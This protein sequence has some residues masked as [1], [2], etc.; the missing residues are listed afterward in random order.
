M[1]K[2]VTKEQQKKLEDEENEEKIEVT[3]QENSEIEE[4][5]STSEI[6]TKEQ[7]EQE[8][9]YQQELEKWF[10]DLEQKHPIE[11]V[12][13]LRKKINAQ[14]ELK[15]WFGSEQ[16]LKTFRNLQLKQLETIDKQN[17]EITQKVL[18]YTEKSQERIEKFLEDFDARDEQL[19]K[20]LLGL[21]ERSEERDR[22]YY[23]RLNSDLD[24][25]IKRDSEW[26]EK[27][28]ELAKLKKKV[29]E[30]QLENERR[31]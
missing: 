11:Y 30:A 1:V 7:I 26:S 24:L 17:E 18:E 31:K 21:L 6:D 28:L 12:N 8:L 3:I 10:K 4:S 27:T 23:E 15:A 13:E 19:N 2:R 9:D 20:K 22:K 25:D 5:Q 16:W 29:Y 14:R